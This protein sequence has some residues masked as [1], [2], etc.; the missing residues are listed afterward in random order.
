MIVFLFT[1]GVSMT[2]LLKSKIDP[3]HAAA[4]WPH[5]YR[6]VLPYVR[7][8]FEE[9]LGTIRQELPESVREEVIQLLRL[10]CDPDPKQRGYVD[11]GARQYNLQR[12]ISRLDFLASKAEHEVLRTKNGRK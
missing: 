2:G 1:G 8:A 6:L 11:L 4:N 9:S 10:L 12:C 5:D 3:Q 7:A